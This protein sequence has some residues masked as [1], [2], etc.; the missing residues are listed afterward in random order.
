MKIDGR[1]ITAEEGKVFRRKSD[2]FTGYG[3]EVDLGYTF[4]LNGKELAEPHL[5]VPEDFE[6]IDDEN[7]KEGGK[8]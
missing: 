5:E 8:L 1:K 6:E 2:G 3:N 4:Y 7:L